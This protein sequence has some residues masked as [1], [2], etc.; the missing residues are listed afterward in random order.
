MRNKVRNDNPTNSISKGG[1]LYRPGEIPILT[2][3]Q[4]EQA[5]IV[6]KLPRDFPIANWENMTA[7]Q[8]QRMISRSG[9]NPQDQ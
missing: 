9:L 1:V 6:D 3:A 5:K 8:Q 7:R 2:K 4:V